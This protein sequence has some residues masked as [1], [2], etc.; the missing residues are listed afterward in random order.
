GVVADQHQGAVAIRRIP[1]DAKQLVRGGE[2]EVVPETERP[3]EPP[4]RRAALPGLPRAHGRG[5][6][7]FV[8]RR[9]Q[10]GKEPAERPAGL[11]AT[12]SERPLFVTVP[13][14]VP[15]RFGVPQEIKISHSPGRNTF[16]IWT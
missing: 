4:G 15:R 2:V 8:R 7:D 10:L 9:I 11:P 3:F 6:E 5:T 12:G 13:G 1:H 16:R 14:S